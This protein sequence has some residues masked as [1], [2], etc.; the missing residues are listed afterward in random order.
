MLVGVWDG[1]IEVAIDA[2]SGSVAV[3][4]GAE[5]ESV[6]DKDGAKEEGFW[7]VGGWNESVS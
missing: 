7:F 6:G 5:E 3:F 1:D 2:S 4:L